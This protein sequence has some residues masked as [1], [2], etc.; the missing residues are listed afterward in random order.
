MAVIQPN[1]SSSTCLMVCLLS[2]TGLGNDPWADFVVDW[3][4]G[5]GGAPGYDNPET[6]LGPPEQYSGEGMDPGVV[7]PFQ[8]AWA[9]HEL[10]SLGSGG[11]LVLGFDD[12][13]E[14]DPANPH[15]IDLIIFGNTGFIDGGYPTGIVN[16]LFGADGGDVFLSD[17][18]VTWHL[19]PGC[20]ADSAWPTLGWLDAQPYD[21]VPGLVPSNPLMPMAPETTWEDLAGMG[22]EDVLLAYG[23]SAGGVGIDLDDIGMD[24]IR[25]VRIQNPESAFFSP[26]I[27]AVVDVRADQPADL[28]DDGLVNVT[29]LLLLLEFW[30]QIEPGHDADF[31]NNGFVDVTDLLFLLKGWTE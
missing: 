12:W 22:W 15:G 26:E 1:V 20:L 23:E 6:A 11:S 10:V 9:P 5:L 13:I 18:G 27:D 14:N 3:E 7:S 4:P 8:P 19:V 24:Y 28:D 21:D 31:D 30:G 2:A 17:D 29:D 16:G 25:Y